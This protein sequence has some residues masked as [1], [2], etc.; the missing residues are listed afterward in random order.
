MKFS[1]KVL[2]QHHQK[3][4]QKFLDPHPQKVQ[5]PVLLRAKV[6]ITVFGLPFL[7]GVA[8]TDPSDLSLSFRTNFPSGPSLKL[9]YAPNTSPAGVGPLTVTLKSGVSLS[10]SPQNSALVISAHFTVSPQNPNPTPAFSLQI[11]PQFGNFS[12]SK[13]SHSSPN[14]NS[15]ATSMGFLPLERPMA[16]KE[17]SLE[18][19]HKESLL[20]GIAIKAKTMF[21]VT[22]QVALNFWWG[23]RFPADIRKQLPFLTVNKIGIEKVVEAKEVKQVEAKNSEGKVG[24]LDFLK[25]L[26]LSMRR[27]VEV[28]QKEN[29]EI[30]QFLEDI[31]YRRWAYQRHSDGVTKEASPVT[32]NSSESEQW[33]AKNGREGN[34]KKEQKKNANT[35]SDL[36]SELQRAIKSASSR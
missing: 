31:R 26:C 24:D 19:P 5:N 35:A 29:R 32:D 21:P 3:N 22:K 2:D 15:D 12:L 30:K 1:L 28:L 34:G 14:P 4:A 25:S 18:S 23:V 20:S 13:T 16:C 27:E 7:S 8:A 9:S 17:M 10:G 11:K 36:E 33:K 6:P